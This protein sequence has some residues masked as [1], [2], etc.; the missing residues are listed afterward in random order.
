MYT[1]QR[2]T[3]AIQIRTPW[4]YVSRDGSQGEIYI[5]HGRLCVCLSVACR[6]PTLLHGPGCNW[7][8]LRGTCPLV[9]H[10]WADLQSYTGFVA[11]TI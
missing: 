11:M 10:Y 6:I 8:N 2:G 4:H 1:T 5:G 9:L 3:L 7:G